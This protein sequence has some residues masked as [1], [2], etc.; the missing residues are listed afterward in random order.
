MFDTL[1]FRRGVRDFATVAVF[2]IGTV[3]PASGQETIADCG[4]NYTMVFCEDDL[5]SLEKAVQPAPEQ[6]DAARVLMRAGAERVRELQVKAQ[7]EQAEL[8][9]WGSLPR[10]K[11]GDEAADEEYTRAYERMM[12]KYQSHAINSTREIAVIEREVL[13]DVM[14]I[15]TKDQIERGWSV[16]ERSRRRVLV[17]SPG[18][19][20]GMGTNP[21]ELVRVLT[22][23]DAERAAIEPIL[24]QRDTAVDAMITRRMKAVR[25]LNDTILAT[26]KVDYAQWNSPGMMTAEIRR[27]NVRTT[28]AVENALAESKREIF[29]RQRVGTELANQYTPAATWPGVQVLAEHKVAKPE[30]HEKM[31]II[32]K[33]CDTNVLKLALEVLRTDDAKVMFGNAEPKAESDNVRDHQEA[34][35]RQRTLGAMMKQ[36]IKDLRATLSAEQLAAIDGAND[37]V[38]GGVATSGDE[39]FKTTRVPKV[40][41]IWVEEEETSK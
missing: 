19:S 30:Q 21:R 20:W 11:G 25:A 34:E 14:S 32:V 28:H 35:D 31:K 18:I 33:E 26:G 12:T 41:S 37:L 8:C 15:L 16:F 9:D 4:A 1:S 17:D 22:L 3:M 24:L 39:L 6:L 7:R 40:K 38:N 2:G 29:K 13:G 36:L 23:D 5:I 10:R 27:L